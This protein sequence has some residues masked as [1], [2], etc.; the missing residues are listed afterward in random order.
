[1]PARTLGVHHLSALE[2]DPVDFVS[3]AAEAG[4]QAISVFTHQ[5]NPQGNLPLVT[6]ENR[7]AM[8]DRLEATGIRIANVDAFMIRPDVDWSAFAAA[9]ELGAALGARR[10]SVLLQDT[11][12]DRVVATLGRFCEL[13]AELEIDAAIEF[14]PLMPAWRS[15]GEVAALIPRVARPNLGISVDAL[16]LIR[17]GGTPGDVAALSPGLISCAQ[18]CD[19]ENL[20]ATSDYLEEAMG[21]RLAPGDGRF[22]LAAL[23]AALPGDTS[24]ELEVPQPRTRPAFERIRHAVTAT[25]KLLDPL[26]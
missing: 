15:I 6:R 20:A 8:R 12:N 1:M 18:L 24:L 13:A 7:R 19:S 2:V 4:C 16:H 21:N 25:R 11:D 5:A 23:I 22:P 17:S 10:A 26:D 14:M 9:L 3:M